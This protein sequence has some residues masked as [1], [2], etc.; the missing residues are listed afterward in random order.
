MFIVFDD[1]EVDPLRGLCYKLRHT[2]K[3]WRYDFVNL[4][5]VAHPLNLPEDV[6]KRYD[7]AFAELP[8]REKAIEEMKHAD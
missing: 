6:K 5:L 4:P 8:L 2:L 1:R 7:Q 3:D